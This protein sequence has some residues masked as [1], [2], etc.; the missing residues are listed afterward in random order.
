[1]YVGQKNI[2]LRKKISPTYAQLKYML[3]QILMPAPH[4]TLSSTT[5]SCSLPPPPTTTKYSNKEYEVLPGSDTFILTLDRE[6]LAGKAFSTTILMWPHQLITLF[7]TQ[8]IINV[9]ICN[10][11]IISITHWLSMLLYSKFWFLIGLGKVT[12][13]YT[14]CGYFKLLKYIFTNQLLYC[15]L[16]KFTSLLQINQLYFQYR[17]S[18]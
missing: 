17:S 12:I 3:L 5:P 11:Y 4:F 8:T 7:L 6:S 1:M 15:M 13:E 16:I 9:Q 18:I 10:L 14:Y 2:Q